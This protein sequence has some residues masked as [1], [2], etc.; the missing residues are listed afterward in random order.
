MTQ[1]A[2]DPQLRTEAWFDPEQVIE[3]WFDPDLIDAAAGGSSDASPVAA[4]G[5]ATV[6]AVGAS[7]AETT[8][9]AAAGV[10]SV[11]AVGSSTA[12]GDAS[13]VPAAGVATVSGAGAST[14]EA[15]ATPADGLATVSGVGF[16]FEGGST[17][18]VPAS[19]VATV[20]AVGSGGAQAETFSGGYPDVPV[21]TKRDKRKERIDLGILPPDPVKAPQVS[22]ALDRE[23][24]AAYDRL[25]KRAKAEPV[26]IP[27]VEAPKPSNPARVDVSPAAAAWVDGWAREY[28]VSLP[29]QAYRQLLELGASA[30]AG[31]PRSNVEPYIDSAAL[32]NY[33]SMRQARQMRAEE[34]FLLLLD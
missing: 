16:S 8:A 7:T 20:S 34:E 10:A 1:G 31:V 12:G 29:P 26:E 2:F 4:A 15:T 17:T 6:S 27:Q 23:A 21:K 3:G 18:A 5:A 33:V 9:T 30:I 22:T 32:E 19:G 11:S 14:A 24:A 28:K 25:I 13:A